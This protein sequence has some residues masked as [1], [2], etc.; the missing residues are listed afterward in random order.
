[1]FCLA[2]PL[3]QFGIGFRRYH[4]Q[5]IS[6]KRKNVA[7][8]I[9]DETIIKAG[10]EYVWLWVAIE[11]KDKAD[12]Q[13]DYIQGKKHVCCRKVYRM[14]DQDSWKTCGINRRWNFVSPSMQIPRIKASYPFIFREKSDRNNNSIYQGL[15]PE[16]FGGYFPCVKKDTI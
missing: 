13:A 5:K 1:M 11:P 6:S 4:P 10:S 9:I 7:E 14:F 8:F 12:S 2:K 15:S 16:G 3:F